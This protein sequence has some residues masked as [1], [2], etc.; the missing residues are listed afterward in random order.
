MRAH[1]KIWRFHE[2]TTFELFILDL[3]NSDLQLGDVLAIVA[4]IGFN[5]EEAL[6]SQVPATYVEG[7]EPKR[8]V[9]FVLANE[10]DTADWLAVGDVHHALVLDASRTRTFQIFKISPRNGEGLHEAKEWL[11]LATFHVLFPFFGHK[12]SSEFRRTSE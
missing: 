2:V 9:L 7:R 4:T 3:K 11:A 5:V 6:K 10:H 1:Q 12:T 8:V